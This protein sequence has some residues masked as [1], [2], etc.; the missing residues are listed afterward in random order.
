ME[1]KDNRYLKEKDKD[2]NTALHIAAKSD[3]L[4]IFDMLLKNCPDQVDDRNNKQ[5][6]P[7]HIAA[8]H[9]KLEIAKKLIKS[10]ASVRIRDK[11]EFSPLLATVRYDSL[12]VFEL[13]LEKTRDYHCVEYRD[14]CENIFEEVETDNRDNPP[15][16]L[17]QIATKYNSCK[18]AAKLISI[19][20]SVYALDRDGHNLVYLAAAN[21]SARVLKVS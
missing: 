12:N 10:N 18:V 8:Q 15:L 9:D 20:A 14:I 2:G 1:A 13:L 5:R 19:G 4:G 16:T 21:G 17:L 11:N 3:N 6:T 7:L